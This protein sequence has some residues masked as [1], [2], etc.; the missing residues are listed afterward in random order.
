MVKIKSAAPPTGPLSLPSAPNVQASKSPTDK[1]KKCRVPYNIAH[2]LARI[3]AHCVSQRDSNPPYTDSFL[4]DPA[5]LSPRQA[6]ALGRCLR[7][8]K[9]GH[10]V[11][12]LATLVSRLERDPP[13][14]GATM[15]TMALRA[16]MAALL[17][18]KQSI[19]TADR[20]QAKAAIM[21]RIR[22]V[23]TFGGTG[24]EIRE[25]RDTLRC[26]EATRSKE[27]FEGE[28]RPTEYDPENPG[29]PDAGKP[30][31]PQGHA[32]VD[33]MYARLAVRVASQGM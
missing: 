17:A 4:C 29:M 33:W 22:V 16:G 1:G 32:H 31:T 9:A 15:A 14:A 24:T 21:G 2:L 11:P 23:E 18:A 12:T 10:R 20:E 3:G 7:A 19:P 26:I 28:A 5:L 30:V 13:G 25:L 8:K 27:V 6:V